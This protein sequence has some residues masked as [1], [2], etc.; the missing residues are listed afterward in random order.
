MLNLLLARLMRLGLRR[1]G[2]EETDFLE[3]F[4]VTP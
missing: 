4:I 3:M 1:N 2:G